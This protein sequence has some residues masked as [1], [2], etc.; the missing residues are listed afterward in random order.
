MQKRNVLKLLMSIG[1][2]FAFFLVLVVPKSALAA[3]PV[4]LKVADPTG[5]IQVTQIFAPR[6]NT[7]H[8]KTICEVWDNEWE[9][10]RTFPLLRELLQK[11]FPD[12][13]I[14]P[15]T[16]L[17]TIPEGQDLAPA[18]LTKLIVEKGCNAVIVGNAG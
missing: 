15:Y 6:L 18:A 3:E 12:A 7:L 10:G 14:V 4:T 1:A 17:P 11:K 13:K 2:V 16:E 9:A 5:A 8:G